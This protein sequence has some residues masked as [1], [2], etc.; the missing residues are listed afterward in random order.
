MEPESPL[1]SRR[2]RLMGG[3]EDQIIRIAPEISGV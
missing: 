3:W 2:Q 1:E